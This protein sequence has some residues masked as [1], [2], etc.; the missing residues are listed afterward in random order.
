MKT[1]IFP[2]SFDPVTNGHLDLIRRSAVLFDKL[3]IGV[4]TNPG[5]QP[6]LPLSERV[7]LLHCLTGEFSNVCVKSF[8]GLLADFV[9]QEQASVI[10]RGL[11]SAHDFEYELP[12]AQANYKLNHHADTIFLAAAPEHSYISSSGVKEIY[13]F[14]GDIRE[15]VPE[16]AFKK[17]RNCK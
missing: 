2:G 10:V 8:G 5:K 9:E 13:R 14:G 17:L 11:R 12:L 3:V 6:L 16:L 15:M 7:E 4:L 1:A